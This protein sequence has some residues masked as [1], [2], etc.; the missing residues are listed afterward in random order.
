MEFGEVLRKG[1]SVTA[2]TYMKDYGIAY[3][4]SI[5]NFEEASSSVQ[6]YMIGVSRAL[7]GEIIIRCIPIGGSAMV[8]D[9]RGLWLLFSCWELVRREAGGVADEELRKGGVVT[10]RSGWYGARDWL[11]VKWL[12]NC[13]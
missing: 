6:D 5:S 10:S 13:G 11:K 7:G 12:V 3:L 4:G 2:L 1:I 9:R 8:A